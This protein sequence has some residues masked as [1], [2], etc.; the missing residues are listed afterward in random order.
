MFVRVH[1]SARIC[2][3]CVCVGV[4]VWVWVCVCVCVW[5]CLC[6]YT[7]VSVMHMVDALKLLG[8]CLK[9]WRPVT[10]P[11]LVEQWCQ[12]LG[13]LILSG[14]TS[15]FPCPNGSQASQLC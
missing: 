12:I 2:V 10:N 13:P 3:E 11:Y 9:L 15:P 8:L 6:V 4:C 5:V 14:F 7:F 1:V